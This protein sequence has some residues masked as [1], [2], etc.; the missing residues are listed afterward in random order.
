MVGLLGA[1]LIDRLPLDV[2]NDGSLHV[3]GCTFSY[4]CFSSN[5]AIYLFHMNGWKMMMKPFEDVKR[6]FG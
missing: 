3:F 4:P 6:D 2:S 1:P 5:Y